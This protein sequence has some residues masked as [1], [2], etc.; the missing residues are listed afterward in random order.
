MADKRDYYEVLGVE[1]TATDDELKKA[2]RKLARQYHP[3]VNP[4][5]KEAEEKFKEVNEAYD[6]LSDASKREPSMTDSGLRAQPEGSAVVPAAQADWRRPG[7][8]RHGRYFRYVLS[9]AAGSEETPQ[10]RA[11]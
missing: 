3:D 2:Y 5:N 6:T 1:K 10:T 8:W 4:G 9:A 7:F 11:A